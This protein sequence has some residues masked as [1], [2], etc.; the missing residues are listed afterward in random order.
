[1]KAA[2]KKETD[3]N[4]ISPGDFEH[5]LGEKNMEEPI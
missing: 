1:M 3:P 5:D 2:I 4:C